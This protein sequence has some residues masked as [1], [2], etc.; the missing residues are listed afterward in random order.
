MLAGQYA[1]SRHPKGLNHLIISNSP[2]SMDKKHEKAGTTDD[3]EYQDAMNVFYAKHL[4]RVQ[5]FPEE[6]AK[7]FQVMAEDPTVYNTM[8]GP[9]EF[10]V[11]GSLKGWTII[12]KLHTIQAS[13]LLI[14][15]FYDEAQDPCVEPYFK[16]IPKVKWITFSN[17]SHTPQFEEREMYMKV[18]GDFVS[19]V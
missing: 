17:S 19:Q 11:V 12:D 9:S 16:H 14:N 4:C 13:T 10:H 3:Q 1:A 18:I 15:G 7:S 6:L 8:N 2:A 5:P